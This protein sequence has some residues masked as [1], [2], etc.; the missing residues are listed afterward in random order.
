M[1]HLCK[2]PVAVGREVLQWIQGR[3]PSVR[4]PA[5]AAD[6]PRR[7]ARREPSAFLPRGHA[8][9]IASRG[10]V[11]AGRWS[12][13]GESAR[14]VG[15]VASDPSGPGSPYGSRARST[16]THDRSASPADR[17]VTLHFLRGRAV[18]APPTRANTPPRPRPGGEPALEEGPV[19]RVCAGRRARTAISRGGRGFA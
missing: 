10:R 3:R 6:R 1:R 19:R 15:L 18:H 11:C 7:P 9:S 4:V 14:Y 12:M 13:Y 17:P 16:R 5:R 8:V 2:P